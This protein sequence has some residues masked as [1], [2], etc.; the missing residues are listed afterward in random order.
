MA[1]ATG[2]RTLRSSGLSRRS[3]GLLEV[4]STSCTALARA[5]PLGLGLTYW[6]D[7]PADGDPYTAVVRFAGH[8]V[9]LKGKAGPGDSFVV[10]EVIDRVLPGSG[11]VAITTRVFDVAPGEWNVTAK[12]MSKRPSVSAEAVA[13][14]TPGAG[15]V[16]RARAPGAHLGVWPALVATGV[17]TALAIQSWLASR[18]QLPLE[19][20][21]ATS[22][23]ASLTGLLGAKGYAL[24]EQRAGLLGKPGRLLS[25]GMCIQGF[26]LGATATV[27]IGMLAAGISVGRFL[28][29]TAP[30]MLFGMSIGRVG[31]FF[32]GCC[33]GRPSASRWALW[34][35]D[36]RVGVRRIPTQPLESAFAAALG[37][38]ALLAVLAGGVKTSGAVFV[39]GVAAYTLG[40]QTLLPLR[41]L[42]RKTSQ[43]RW[44][45]ALIAAFVIAADIVVA[46]L[47]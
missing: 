24:A 20:T 42:P 21:L 40:R 1:V 28:D 23:A 7:A 29:I 31:C 22:M 18:A 13:S 27:V 12:L 39:G 5:E 26:L 43:G 35:S 46:A 25:A 33:A 3:T 11:R 2:S 32:G 17:G 8:R 41:D 36:R 10:S 34:S 16:I 47:A 4:T 14:G 6:F 44:L 19:A 9:G 37:V 38:S 30:G 15:P 45:V